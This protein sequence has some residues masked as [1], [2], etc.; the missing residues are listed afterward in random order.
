VFKIIPF[1]CIISAVF[2]VG[3]S[4]AKEIKHKIPMTSI[5]VLQA[6]LKDPTNLSYVKQFISEDFTYVSLN[7][8]NPDLKKKLN[9]GQELTKDQKV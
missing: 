4:Q 3:I 2:N 6:V 1:I 9:R 8:E 5:E 7:Y